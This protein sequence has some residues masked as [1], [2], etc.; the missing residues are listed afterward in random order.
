MDH[1]P[2]FLDLKSRACLVVGGGEVAARKLRLLTRAAGPIEVVAP[3]VV[4]EIA[5]LY[6]SGRV[7]WLQDRFDPCQLPGKSLVIA[8]TSDRE[9]NAQVSREAMRRGLLVNVVD[10]PKLSNFI[11]PAIVDR[12]PLVVAISSGGSMPVLAR[13]VRA[14]LEDRLPQSLGDLASAAG[15][16]REAVAARLPDLT[17]RRH[18]WE[19]LLD[20]ALA[21]EAVERRLQ[22]ILDETSQQQ[23]PGQVFLVGAGPGDPDLLTL[24]AAQVLQQADVIVYDRLVG[25]AILERARRDAE[26]IDVGKQAG[27]HGIGQAQINQLLL[28]FAEQG[29]MVCRLKGGDPAFFARAGEELHTLREAGIEVNLVPGITAASGCAAAVG[30]PLTDRDLAHSVTL[31]TAHCQQQLEC[32]DTGGMG[33]SDRTL[34]FY[35]PVRHL[36]ALKRRLAEEGLPDDTP[37]ALIENGTRPDQRVVKTELADLD[38]A[39]RSAAVQS[40]ALL[41]VG[42]VLQLM[43]SASVCET[44]TPA[45]ASDSEARTAA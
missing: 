13:R 1:L 7:R 21:G 12:S 14:W 11:S 8:A 34:V 3:E 31:A 39:A 23:A 35:M 10:Q 32:L 40:P 19:R 29:K 4:P 43:P 41:V 38:T 28:R 18:F 24:K 44:V 30:I 17:P 6:M 26:M 15:R 27:Q 25:P 16:F 20:R 33:R 36:A 42:R 37:C 2:V 22:E 5:R 45:R 9:V